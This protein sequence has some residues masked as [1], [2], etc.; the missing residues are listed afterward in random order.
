MPILKPQ[1]KPVERQPLGCKLE[2]PIFDLLKAYCRYLAST[3]E[4]VL[5]ESLLFTFRKDVE[6]RQWLVEN[7]PEHADTLRSR[8]FEPIKAAD[9]KR[10][11]AKE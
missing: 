7:E 1:A 11:R 2:R 5:R 3:Q 6:F 9:T 8:L 4:Y 10:A